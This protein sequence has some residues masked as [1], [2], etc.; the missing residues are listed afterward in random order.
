M[1]ALVDVT[2]YAHLTDLELADH[3]NE[4]S[5]GPIDVLIG[6]N[7]YWS[8]VTGELVKGDSGPVAMNSVFGW[9]L[10]GPVSS[11]NYNSINHTYV[12]ITDAVDDAPTDQQDNLLS[13]ALKR[14]WDSETIGIYDGTTEKPANLFLPEINFDGTR[15]K[16]S[17]P[18][19]NEHPNIPDHLHLCNE[20]L[21]YLHQ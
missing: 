9:L 10:S 12:V 11:F 14:F 19:K 15:Y 3:R 16:V 5:S 2:K 21:K 7:Y 6:S 20:R 17:L 13:Q 18:W 4:Q 8:I 1:P